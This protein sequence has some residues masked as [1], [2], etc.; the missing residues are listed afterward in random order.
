MFPRQFESIWRGRLHHSEEF[1]PS[2]LSFCSYFPAPSILVLFQYRYNNRVLLLL[3]YSPPSPP[4]T[5]ATLSCASCFKLIRSSQ[6]SIRRDP[7]WPSARMP[8][9]SFADPRMIVLF[10]LVINIM[11]QPHPQSSQCWHTSSHSC[12]RLFAPGVIWELWE[13]YWM[14]HCYVK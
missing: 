7:L 8:L 1:S 6:R 9:A 14:L 11:S 4:L 12:R 10:Y 3:S 13:E 2:N 5:V